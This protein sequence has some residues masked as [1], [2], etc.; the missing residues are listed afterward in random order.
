MKSGKAAAVM[1]RCRSTTL[2]P[3]TL[4]IPEASIAFARAEI[5]EE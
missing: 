3:I 2:G 4:D 1:Y 5:R